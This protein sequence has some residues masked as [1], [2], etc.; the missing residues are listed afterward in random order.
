MKSE[1]KIIYNNFPR[2]WG[3]FNCRQI[4]Y[5]PEETNG[6]ELMRNFLWFQNNVFSEREVQRRFY[7]N[8]FA[9]RSLKNALRAKEED[10]FISEFLQENM[11]TQMLHHLK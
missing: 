6:F 3:K 10:V 1:D 8:F 7:K 4:T 11:L 9:T 2:D 5:R